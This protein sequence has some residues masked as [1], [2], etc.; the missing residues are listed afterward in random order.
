MNDYV[1]SVNLKRHWITKEIK[2]P[3]SLGF[4]AFTISPFLSCSP[5]NLTG[6]GNQG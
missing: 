3:I 4:L 1:F 5:R 6:R 2:N